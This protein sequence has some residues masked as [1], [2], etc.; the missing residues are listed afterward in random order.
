LF[1]N[2]TPAEIISR[3]LV[4]MIAFTVHEFS[5]A[6]TADRFGDDTPR[7]QGRL[8]LN[9]FVH[10]DPIGSLLLLLVGFGWAK[11]VMVD[12]FALQRRSPAAPMLVALAGPASNFIMAVLASI[13]VRFG[14]V[15]IS[16]SGNG[17]IPTAYGFIQEFVLINLVLMLFNLI[18][19]FPLDGEKILHYFLP[20]AGQNIL[21]GLRQYGPMLLLGVIFLLPYLGIDLLQALIFAPTRSLFT[22][23]LL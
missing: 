4:L 19:I 23:L 15:A 5:H 18:P 13:P 14:L 7:R 9:P 21:E 8:T 1:S 22:W 6:W 12:Y 16:S 17:Y 2:L 3:I 11:P 10:L 20:P